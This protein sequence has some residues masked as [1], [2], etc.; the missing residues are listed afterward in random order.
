MCHLKKK[1]S[2]LLN[3]GILK[4]KYFLH[5]KVLI[6]WIL[7]MKCVHKTLR[8]YREKF[9]VKLLLGCKVRLVVCISFMCVKCKFSTLFI[10]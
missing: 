2:V 6:S 4:M 1:L 10:K 3:E 9:V 8:E 7:L 5:I